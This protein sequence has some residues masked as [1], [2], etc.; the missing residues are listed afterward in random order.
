MKYRNLDLIAQ[1]KCFKTQRAASIP[2]QD[3]RWTMQLQSIFLPNGL[4]QHAVRWRLI[5]L[6]AV[7]ALVVSNLSTA[8]TDAPGEPVTIPGTEIS[9]WGRV[10]EV[11][12]RFGRPAGLTP[13]VPAVLILHGSGVDGRGAF[14]AKPNNSTAGGGHR[15]T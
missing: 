2:Q 11:P 1:A 4:I 14:Y 9:G 12:A 3:W 7:A 6:I 13:K 15:Y 8:Q 10:N 5:L